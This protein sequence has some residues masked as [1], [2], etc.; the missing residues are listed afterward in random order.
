MSDETGKVCKNL[1]DLLDEFGCES[2]YRLGRELY[3]S[4]ACG[5]WISFEL[6]DRSIHYGDPAARTSSPDWAEQCT[7]VKIGSIV[8]GS[9]AEI[10]PYT[11][12]F[13]FSMA[14]FDATVNEVN[15]QASEEWDS[16]NEDEGEDCGGC[17]P[18]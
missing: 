10:G 5:P 14:Q 4:T 15:D 17:H 16:A 6:P 9:D 12:S 8:E 3:K 1:V 13:P 18:G 2:P 11:L 7:G